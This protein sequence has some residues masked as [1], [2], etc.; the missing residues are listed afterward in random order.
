MDKEILLADDE[1]TFRKTFAKVLQEEGMS[2]T[3][4]ADGCEAIEAVIKRPFAATFNLAQVERRPS[5]ACIH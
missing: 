4:V 1:V 2:V 5:K 3:A